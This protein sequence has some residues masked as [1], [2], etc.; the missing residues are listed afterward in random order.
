MGKVPRYVITGGGTGGHIFVALAIG[1]ALKR[2]QPCE[3]LFV[4]A[5]GRMEMRMVPERGHA[6]RGLWIR[7]FERE[8]WF[9]NLLLPAQCVVSILQAFYIL[10]CFKPWLIVG[11]GGYASAPMLVAGI[12]SRIPCVIQEQ[13]AK[14]GWVN[15]CMSR[16]A[17]KIFVA[18]SHTDFV[19]PKHKVVVTGNPVR[20]DVLRLLEPEKAKAY[21]NFQ[22]ERKTLLVLGGSL[23]AQ[24]LNQGLYGLLPRLRR[25]NVQ[26]LW[27]TGRAHHARWR[28]KVHVWEELRMVSFFEDVSKAYAAA[29][30]IVARAG[31]L[32]ISELA[33]VQKPT[34]LV[35]SPNVTDNHQYE[36][37]K[38]LHEK[39]A[40]LLLE[41]EEVEEKLEPVLWDLLN[42]PAKQQAL[43]ENIRHFARPEAT[44]KIVQEVFQV[45]P[46]GG[47]T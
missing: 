3:L 44:Q 18:Y 35:P 24:R 6:I 14:P 37:A 8:S 30:V 46:N 2:T 40:V 1:E 42:D 25:E 41:D 31:A 9:R 23:G 38:R 36:N 39:G 7:G 29:D 12:I 21:F 26:V 22:A 15:R 11:T 27:Q 16:Y 45:L 28:A 10:W 43:R 13:N 17:K 32:T 34:L 33:I 47:K 5:R 20:D 19:L 4:G